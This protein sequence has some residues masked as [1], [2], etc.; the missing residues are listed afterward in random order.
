MRA[1]YWQEGR[2]RGGDRGR[3]VSGLVPGQELSGYATE[4]D[5]KKHETPGKP[6][7]LTGVFITGFEKGMDYVDDECRDQDIAADNVDRPEQPPVWY[8]VGNGL[9]AF[10]GVVRMGY[11]IEEQKKSGDYLDKEGNQCHKSQGAKKT[12]ALRDSVLSEKSG[13]ELIEPDSHLNPSCYASPH[14]YPS[15]KL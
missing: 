1:D 10:K 11:V 5:Q 4:Q 9:N 6:G 15:L 14:T 13:D 8:G 12:G 7:Q 2:Y 3:P